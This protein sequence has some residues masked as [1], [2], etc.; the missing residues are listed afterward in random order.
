MRNSVLLAPLA[1]LLL[2]GVASAQQQNDQATM[3]ANYE[4]KLQKEFVAFGGWVTD[5]DVARERAAK[6]GKIIFAYFSRS[7]AK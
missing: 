2:S 6:E 1:G 4:A 5:Y 7:Y 3:K